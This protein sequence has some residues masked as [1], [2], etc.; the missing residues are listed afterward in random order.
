MIVD[1]RP[2]DDLAVERVGLEQNIHAGPV[3]MKEGGV[4]INP[5]RFLAVAL[6]DGVGPEVG[7]LGGHVVSPMNRGEFS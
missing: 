4:E 2:Q 3:L 1:E 5:D 7:K 6:D